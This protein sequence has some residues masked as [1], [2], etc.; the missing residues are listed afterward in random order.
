M[1]VAKGDPIAHFL[2]CDESGYFPELELHMVRANP[3]ET[4]G[5]TGRTLLGELVDNNYQNGEF[6]HFDPVLVGL[7]PR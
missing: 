7:P 3:F 4:R 1:P 5:M 2:S 6:T